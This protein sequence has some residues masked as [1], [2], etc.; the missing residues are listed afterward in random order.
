MLRRRFQLLIL[1]QPS[2]IRVLPGF[3]PQIMPHGKDGAHSR[4]DAPLRQPETFPAEFQQIQYLQLQLNRPLPRLAVEPIQP[5]YSLIRRI[6]IIEMGKPQQLF[7]CQLSQLVKLFLVFG[8]SGELNGGVKGAV[9]LPGIFAGRFLAASRQTQCQAEKQKERRA[10]GIFVH[11][12][13][14][15]SAS[16]WMRPWPWA[17]KKSLHWEKWRQPKKPLKAE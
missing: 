15:F 8:V 17:S 2:P 4:V 12:A 7:F 9:N 5:P 14:S 11:S 13:Q 10:P 16:H 3:Q 1:G 6:D